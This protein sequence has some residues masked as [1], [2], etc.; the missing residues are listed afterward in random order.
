MTTMQYMCHIDNNEQMLTQIHKQG[1]II[2]P[3]E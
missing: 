3:Q 2:K 1:N